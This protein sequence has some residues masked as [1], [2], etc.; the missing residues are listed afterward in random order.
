MP[1]GEI[2]KWKVN[3]DARG[4]FILEM[5]GFVTFE[6]FLRDILSMRSNGKVWIKHG[7]NIYS[8]VYSFGV[9]TWMSDEFLNRID[10]FQVLSGQANGWPPQINYHIEIKD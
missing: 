8:L 3:Q 2:M 7:K 9:I 1:H 10:K 6:A 4:W 5:N